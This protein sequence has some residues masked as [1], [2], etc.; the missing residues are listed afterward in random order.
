MVFELPDAVERAGYSTAT[1]AR[2]DGTKIRRL[3]W[4]MKYDIP[5][6]IERTIQILRSTMR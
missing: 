4:E 2:L 5:A 1:K 3:G 6:G